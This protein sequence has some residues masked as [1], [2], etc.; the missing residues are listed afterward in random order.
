MINGRK[1]RR[2]SDTVVFDGSERCG[3][4]TS[5]AVDLA[6]EDHCLKI[7]IAWYERRRDRN[8]EAICSKVML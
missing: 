8:K 1:P 6:V 3:I 4:G 2:K 7:N 5:T